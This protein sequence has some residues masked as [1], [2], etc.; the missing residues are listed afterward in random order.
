MEELDKNIKLAC[1]LV[2]YT[3]KTIFLTGKAGTG[4]T[5]FLK[6]LP[7][8]TS[9]RIV[10]VAPTGVAALNA[11][12]VTIHSMFQLPFSPYLPEEAGFAYVNKNEDG[13]QKREMF[14]L[15]SRKIKMLRSIDL[16]VVDEVSMVR[17]DVLDAIDAV[18]R[19]YRRSNLPFAGV[20]LLMIGDLYQLTPVV[21]DD[22][23]QILR[24]FYSSPY[25]FDSN[26]LKKL[27][28]V[29][30]ELTHIFRQQDETFISILNEIRNNSLSQQSLAVLNSRVGDLDDTEECIR[31]TTHNADANSLNN[32]KL[33]ELPDE[34]FT[35]PA[36]IKDN[37]PDYMYPTDKDLVLKTGAQ[38]MFI[39]NDSSVEKLYFNGKI[40]RIVEMDDTRIMVQC[41]G[42]YAP[43][44]VKME[45]W[46][47]TQY[48]LDEKTN[49]IEQKVIGTF[50]QYPLRL[51]WAI[52]VHKSQGL[53]FEKA[54]I[55][56][57]A[58]FAFGQVYVALSRCKS[59]DGLV[60][61]SPIL[62]QMIKT[63]YEVINFCDHVRQLQPD[64][65]SLSAYVVEY[66]RE[67]ILKIFSMEN[68]QRLLNEFRQ[69]FM[70]N[71]GK[72]NTQYAEPILKIMQQFDEQL[73]SVNK[74]FVV[75]LW[76]IFQSKPNVSLQEDEFLQERI[77]KAAEYYFPKLIDI[78]GKPFEDMLIE[79]DNAEVNEEM[80][81]VLER[82]E[83]EYLKKLCCYDKMRT[84]FS[85]EMYLR[86]VS[87][88]ENNFRLRFGR[89][90][91]NGSQVQNYA[92]SDKGLFLALNKWRKSVASDLDSPLYFVLSQKSLLE[93]VEKMPRTAKALSK[94]S[95]IGA[96]KI[97]QFGNEIL[98]IVNE[99]CEAKGMPAVELQVE[100][101]EP[102]KSKRA[103]KQKEIVE[104]ATE[105]TT[106]EQADQVAEESAKQPAQTEKKLKIG[107]T[108]K[109]TYE[110]YKSGKTIAEIAQE[111]K[112][113]EAT[114]FSHLK[115]FVITGEILPEELI[116]KERFVAVMEFIEKNKN[117]QSLKEL[118]E[119]GE[120]VFSYSDLHV[121]MAFK[122]KMEAEKLTE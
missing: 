58:A 42:D 82:L 49:E 79:C 9:K 7:N 116:G 121:G 39:R 97:Q 101:E 44:E 69:L 14:R 60:L 103:T 99:Y 22:E 47:N 17:S 38:V 78:V 33:A 19:H 102:K 25:F 6:N 93:I 65:T 77:A 94:I 74:R 104:A 40:G 2:K 23:W 29:T 1:E 45:K 119:K 26:A 20:Q 109:L 98:N 83:T 61:K 8:I 63:D 56:V 31:L 5:T 80:R 18:L 35:F 111:R 96:K 120:G 53:T 64:A 70:S 108:Y 86:I 117:L 122:Q 89:K 46:E 72:F 87:D 34:E 66:Q 27:N 67:I 85:T 11:G 115:R 95:G 76:H 106:T 51:A 10:V 92:A 16:L 32:T 37:F 110:M 15:N 113:V 12:G 90:D 71:F 81:G 100:E 59:L 68:L 112:L 54:V 30:V 105:P 50:T 107:E 84:G 75:Q 13:T 48:V 62:P 114:I 118:F 57:R 28:Y 55:D 43:I 88:V 73:F 24:N 41:A 4:K 91:A 52:T 21:K 36:S 3:S